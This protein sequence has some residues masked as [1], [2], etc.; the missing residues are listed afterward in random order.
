MGST[1]K[2]VSERMQDDL[3]YKFI[4]MSSREHKKFMKKIIRGATKRQIETLKKAAG[5]KKM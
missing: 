5:M 4:H 1:Q 3:M 2:N